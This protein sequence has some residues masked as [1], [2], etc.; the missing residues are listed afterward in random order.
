MVDEIG[1]VV[2]AAGMSLRMEQPKLLLPWGKSTII[3]EVIDAIQA[4]RIADI[5]VVTGAFH[6]QITDLVKI[7]PVKLAFNPDFED[8]SMLHSLQVGLSALSGSTRAALVALGD[9]PMIN[10]EV[11]GNLLAEFHSKQP[12]FLV[13]SFQGHRGHPWIFDRQYFG[14]IMAMPVQATLRDFLN[15]HAPEITYLDV[16]TDSILVDIDTPEDYQRLQNKDHKKKSQP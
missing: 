9:Q 14:E 6:Q 7:R 13:P 11:I 4:N 12:C 5:I 15:L 1:A 8:G 2:L 16:K 3:E 10:K